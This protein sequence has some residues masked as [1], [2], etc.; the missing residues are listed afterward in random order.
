[1]TRT[2]TL[3]LVFSASVTAAQINTG[4]ISGVVRDSVGGV[5]PGA[6]V[7]ATHT[8]SGQKVERVTDG[9]GRYFL[10]AL[11]LGVWMVEARLTGLATQTR[12]I[13]VEV[14]RTLAVDFSLTVQGLTEQ[15]EVQSTSPL[16]QM[17]T[18]EISDVIENREVVQLPLNGRNFLALAQLSDAVVIPP[19]GTRGEALQQTG[20]LPNVGGQRS[21]HNIYLL[22]GTKV[23]D[24]LFNNLVINPSVDSIEEFKIQKSMYPAEFGGKASA[25]I[26]VVTRGGTNRFRGSAF[27]FRRDDAF[28]AP[29]YFRP[30]GAE[31][32][33]LRQDQF[34]GTLGGPIRRNESFFFASFE[35]LRMKRSLTRTFSVPGAAVRSGDFSGLSTICDPL[36]IPTTGSCAPFAG[37]RIPSGRID[38]IAAALLLHVPAAT[39]GGQTQNLTAIEEQGRDLNQ[40][41]V[42]LDHQLTPNDQILARFSTFDADEAQP[43]GTSALQEALVPGFGRSL[44]THTRNLVASHTHIFGTSLLNELRGGWMTVRG[45]Q[46]SVNAGN[47]FAQDVGLLGVTS[48]PRDTGFPQVSTGGLYSTFGDPTI[49]TTRDNQHVELFDNVTIDRGAHRLKFG[50]YFFH[51]QLRPEQPDNARGAFTYTGQ[52][53]GNALADFLLGYPTSAVSGIGRGDEN[54]RTNWLHLYAQD[55]WQARS[56]LTFNLGL[57]YEFNQHM[58]DVDNRLSSIDLDA[59]RFVIASDDDGNINS[60][61]TPLLGQI[62][63]PYVTSASADWGRGLLDP[64]AVR[65]APRAGFA[66]ALDDARAVVR[67][68]YGIFLNQWA[69]SVQTAFARNLPYFF[70]KQVDVPSDV[71]VPSLRTQDILTNNATGTV[72]GSIMDYAYSVEYSQTW[73]GGLQYALRPTTMAEVFYMGTWTLGADN[74]TVRNVPE[75]GA[76][77]IQARRPIPQLS[78]INAI[79]FDGKSIYHALTLRVERR[80]ADRFAYNVSY[81]LSESKDDAS[82]PGATESETNVPQNVRN[83]FD[84]TGEWARSSFDHTHQFIASGVY[85]FPFFSNATGL[86]RALLGD[87]RANAI[88]IAQTGAPFTVNLSVDRA[89]IGAGPAQRPDQLRDPNLPG[90]ERRPERWFDTS[91]FALQAPFTFGSA[92]RNSVIGPGYANVDFALAKTWA[93]G[94]QGRQLEFRWEVFNLFNRANFD[95]PNR[96]FGNAN[97]GRIFSAKSPREM[98]FGLRFAF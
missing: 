57:R 3:L 75:P 27:E 93:A 10:P 72:G 50:A 45:G 91:A 15:V 41:S 69:Y 32:P 46:N 71:R 25:L 12:T 23:T 96:I 68:G 98:Q 8:A 42:R 97:F 11:R 22:D 1:M 47:T 24:E 29:N 89:N 62:P 95:L 83:V 76:G 48:D 18:A 85:Q 55:D 87:W 82:S 35:G 9:E 67:G 5:L 4:E 81:T 2:I 77:P 39:A 31:V 14:G 20:P 90:G 44:T 53:T 80:L 88:F 19:G 59:G 64:S 51:L 33:P 30:F 17:T 54:G 58:Y 66:L 6:T 38:P 16:L 86:T 52:F 13:V 60:S 84:E 78:R 34:G 36:T 43:F 92:P 40:L 70:T 56:N 74:A 65:L 37:N 73:S 21:G 49:F 94:G 79:R 61:A 63:I 26:N 7:V 28:D